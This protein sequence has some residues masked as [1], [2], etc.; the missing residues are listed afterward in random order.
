[1]A[2]PLVLLFGALVIGQREMIEVELSGTSG[3]ISVRSQSSTE[4]GISRGPRQE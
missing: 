1:M 3:T 2:L 4:L